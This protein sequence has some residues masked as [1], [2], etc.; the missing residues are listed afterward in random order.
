MSYNNFQ[1]GLPTL[2]SR[3]AKDMGTSYANSQ[4]ACAYATAKTVDDALKVP[5]GSQLNLLNAQ[6]AGNMYLDYGRVQNLMAPTLTT[7]RMGNNNNNI[8]S[9]MY[10]KGCYPYLDYKEAYPLSE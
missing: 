6:M 9:S 2:S 1:S 7:L 8:G 5:L 3:V 4:G 10:H